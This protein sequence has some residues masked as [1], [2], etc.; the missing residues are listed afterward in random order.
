MPEAGK[1][2]LVNTSFS[3][4]EK[5]VITLE[6]RGIFYDFDPLQKTVTL[7]FDMAT[8][9]CVGWRDLASG[10]RH[11]CP[12]QQ[13]VDEKYEQCQA[14]QDRTG[15]NPAFYHAL[16][17][18]KQQ[19]IRNQEPHFLYLAYFAPGVIKVGI[20]YARR[21]YSRLLEQGARSALILD[22]FPTALIARQYEARIAASP[23]IQE[24]IQLK[25]KLSLL[26]V[27]HDPIHAKREL[28]SKKQELERMLQVSFATKEILD[29]EPR[30]FPQRKPNFAS[31]YDCTLNHMVTGRTL[32]MVGSVLFTT[33]EDTVLYFAVK[34][35]VGYKV[36]LSYTITPMSL[37]ARQTSL[38]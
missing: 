34:K 19:E 12:D 20:S 1:Y 38:F 36:S 35:H 17:V 9:F 31:A 25:K 3:L 10:E 13:M 32:G 21:G 27:P 4:D 15:F 29:L 22:T 2:L 7:E 16:T 6:R 33:Y 37:P 18:S 8:R 24:T 14:C 28:L 11:T 23:D 5:P 26:N 30:Y